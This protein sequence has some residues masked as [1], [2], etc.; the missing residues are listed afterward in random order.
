MLPNFAIFRDLC[1]ENWIS[2]RINLQMTSDF[3][4]RS[5]LF[6]YLRD[7]SKNGCYSPRKKYCASRS[8][9]HS[10]V[11]DLLRAAITC[12]PRAV[13][14][15]DGGGQV[16]DPLDILLCHLKPPDFYSRIDFQSIKP[17]A[18]DFPASSASIQ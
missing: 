11:L 13:M 7:S 2:L 18:I 16:S 5:R 4:L 6:M 1:T 15:P 10:G 3:L 12:G 17:C 8:D 9:G 14:H